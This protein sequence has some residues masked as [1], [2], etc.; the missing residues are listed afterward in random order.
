MW[1]GQSTPKH[2][3][4]AGIARFTQLLIREAGFRH[5]PTEVGNATGRN[6]ISIIIPCHRVIGKNRSLCGF[7]GGLERKKYLL[8]LE[9]F[10]P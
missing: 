6:P 8:K 5:L 4:P 3:L 1:E 9:N 7:A 10:V 2:A